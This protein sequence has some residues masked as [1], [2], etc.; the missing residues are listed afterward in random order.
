M[1]SGNRA[2]KEVAVNGAQQCRLRFRLFQY[3]AGCVTLGYSDSISW[4]VYNDNGEHAP[5]EMSSY[6]SSG[7]CAKTWSTGGVNPSV[8]EHNLDSRFPDAVSKIF[9]F[10]PHVRKF[11]VIPCCSVLELTRT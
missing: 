11:G 9:S 4:V 7:E 10:R 1:S 8:Q 2:R 5:C 3:L 6:S